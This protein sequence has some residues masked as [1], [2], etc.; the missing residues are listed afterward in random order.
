[1]PPGSHLEGGN[2]ICVHILGGRSRKDEWRPFHLSWSLP[3]NPVA[4][5]YE[6]KIVKP[7]NVQLLGLQGICGA[8]DCMGGAGG[9]LRPI[10]IRWC[11]DMFGCLC[12]CFHCMCHS[13]SYNV[14]AGLERRW[15]MLFWRNSLW[16]QPLSSLCT[17]GKIFAIFHCENLCKHWCVWVVMESRR[18]WGSWHFAQPQLTISPPFILVMRMALH[19]CVTVWLSSVMKIP[20]VAHQTWLTLAVVTTHCSSWSEGPLRLHTHKHTYTYT[21]PLEEK[22]KKKT[23]VSPLAFLWGDI[24]T[25]CTV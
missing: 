3:C 2:L 14:G 18:S 23:N 24:V 11:V 6:V 20:H 25:G 9:E 19:A 22:K 15:P 21:K 7:Q 1:M 13:M 8:P 17:L 12:A 10:C 4:L 16:M 5:T